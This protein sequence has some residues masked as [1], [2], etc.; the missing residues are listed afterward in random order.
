[1]ELEPPLAVIRLAALLFIHQR[2]NLTFDGGGGE[3]G[4]T[5]FVYKPEQ[6]NT[7]VLKCACTFVCNWPLPESV[8]RV[9]RY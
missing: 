8:D 1:M 6:T 5:L 9:L 7:H 4:D 2:N 3:G